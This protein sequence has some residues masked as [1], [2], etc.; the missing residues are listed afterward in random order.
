MLSALLSIILL[1][2]LGKAPYVPKGDLRRALDAQQGSH[3]LR[4]RTILL[5]SHYLGL[6]AKELALL[7]VGDVFDL[8]QGQVREVVRLLK[9]KGDKFRE[10]FLVNDEVRD[11]LRRYL[12]TRPA[13]ADAPLFLSQK[14]GAFSPNTMQKLL[15]NIYAEAGIAA[16]S[17][18]GRRSF[19]TRLI[20][21]G[22][23]IYAV[24]E[25]MGH[26]SITTTQ[27]Y[28]ATSP[29]RLKKFAGAL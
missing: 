4:N 19:A 8:H 18:S 24:M 15:H 27:G 9:T 21:S 22:A 26:S 11:H 23:D 5:V 7:L 14:G 6:R 29:E 20:Q 25:M 28:F 12:V 3:A 13:R 17:H 1:M 16:S 2:R 10:A